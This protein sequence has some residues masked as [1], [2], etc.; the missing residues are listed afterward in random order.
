[1]RMAMAFPASM[2]FALMTSGAM[3]ETEQRSFE[4]SAGGR[5]ALDADWG[6][7]EVETWDRDAVDVVVERSQK[8]DQLEFDD[9]GDTVTVRARKEDTGIRSWFGSRGSSPVFR[10][11]VPHRFDLDLKTVGGHIGIP[12]IDGD[13]VARTSG[14][15]LTIGEVTGSVQGRTSGGSIHITGVDGSVDAKTS[16]GAIRLGRAGGSV[17]ARTTGGSI[18]IGDAGGH[19]VAHTTGGSIR[20]GDV[21]GTLDAKTTGGSIRATL[22]QQPEGDSRLRTTGGSIELSVSEEVGVDIDARTTGGRVLSDLRTPT[23]VSESK[24][25]LVTPVNGGGP[26]LTLRTTG[27]SIRLGSP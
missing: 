12:D 6:K 21:G 9:E 19:T 3:A 14:G 18:H 8:F 25:A 27:G 11:T 2:V 23:P 5:F 17:D 10:I 20:L 22:A 26:K 16:G 1:M 15:K 4:A 13:I 7:V 24:S